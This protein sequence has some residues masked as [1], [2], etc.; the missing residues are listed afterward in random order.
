MNR[1][2][3]C[4]DLKTFFASVECVERNLDP[5]KT[6]LIVADPSRG[7]GA[8]CLA[9]SPKLKQRGIKNRCRVFEIPK[10]IKPIVAKPRMKK[11]IEYS[12]KTYG[13]YLKYISKED[14]H[15]YSIDEC[16]LDITTYLNMYKKSPIELAKTIIEDV[17]KTT[18]ITATA[19]IGTNLYLA[20]IAL[21]ITAKHVKSN[22]GCLNIEKY[23]QELWNHLPLT[24]FWQVGKGIEQRLNNLGLYT[25]KD[26]A[27]CDEAILFKEFGINARYLIDHSKGIEPCTIKDIKAYKPKS[28][29]ISNSQILH[30]PYSHTQTRI[31]LMEMIDY[32]V[33]RIVKD[34]K[35]T[36][37]IGFHIG[38]IN[39]TKPSLTITKKIETPSNSYKTIKDILLKE[40]DKKI[41]KYTKIKRVGITFGGFTERKY[42]EY[43]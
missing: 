31:I 13:V 6:E 37:T 25:M 4:I 38:Y 24:D 8:I 23:K 22:I 41:D 9:I 14:I 1:I 42:E 28:Q 12:A 27:L 3:L 21:D 39:E 43:D 2:Y 26:I 11:Y 30:Q 17:H 33:L 10:Y 19:G 7:P 20:K 35:V 18:G 34:K 15:V 32:M 40:Y 16:F 29:S 36:S 5:F